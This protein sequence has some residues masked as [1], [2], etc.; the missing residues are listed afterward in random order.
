MIVSFIDMTGR[1]EIPADRVCG[2]PSDGAKIKCRV[3]QT[4]GKP[5]GRV[6]IL[7]GMAEHS[8]RYSEFGE[9]LSGKGY[10]VFA[11]DQR[12][13][14]LTSAESSLPL[15]YMGKGVDFSTL[16]KDAAE[17]ANLIPDDCPLFIFSHSMGTIVARLFLADAGAELRER[18][19]GVVFSGINEMPSFKE[20]I[21]LIQSSMQTLIS[22]PASPDT[23]L[24]KMQFGGYNSSFEKNKTFYQW[25]SGDQSIVDKYDKDP[26]CGT[27]FSSSFFNSLIKASIEASGKKIMSKIPKNIKYLFLSGDMD[28]VGG[29]KTGIERNIEYF[30]KNAAESAESLI[31]EGGRHEM[32]NET[33]RREVFTAILEWIEKNSR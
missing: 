10:S 21:A 19:K 33:N 26:F 3:W 30:R 25:L 23:F 14:G 27:A 8:E 24:W 13:N 1:G 7:H 12:G 16:I 9:F 29:F 15:G 17:I 6:Q 5:K 22:G 20:R 4:E 28:A 31:F 32:L 11:H 18:I 2:N